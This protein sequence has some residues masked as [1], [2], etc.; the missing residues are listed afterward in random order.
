[1]FCNLMSFLTVFQSYQDDEKVIMEG[2]VQWISVYGWEEICY[3]RSSIPGP[4][5]QQASA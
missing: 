1:M 5:D 3:E 2:C 4:L